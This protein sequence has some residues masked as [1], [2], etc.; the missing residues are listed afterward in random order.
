MAF[1]KRKYFSTNFP[2]RP[3][4]GPPQAR[5]A[6]SRLSVSGPAFKFDHLIV[7]AAVRACEWIECASRHGTP[8]ANSRMLIDY[9]TLVWAVA[10]ST[11]SISVASSAWV[12]TGHRCKFVA[13]RLHRSYSDNPPSYPA[14]LQ[15]RFAVGIRHPSLGS[16]E[17]AAAHDGARLGP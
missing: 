3:T 4:S 5:Q 14:V 8:P 1:R 9:G 10:Q 13:V 7:G 17:R 12:D 2:S 11:R 15:F 16:S 6:I